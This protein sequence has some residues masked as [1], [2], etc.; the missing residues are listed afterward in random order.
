[1]SPN[2]HKTFANMPNELAVR[3]LMQRTALV[4]AADWRFGWVTAQLVANRTGLKRR[5]VRHHLARL[6][7]EGDVMERQ[8]ESDWRSD[9]D[10]DGREYRWVRPI[11]SGPR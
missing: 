1:M 7:D 6:L 10:D 5:V 11:D 3:E 2:E 8:R 4:D 9:R